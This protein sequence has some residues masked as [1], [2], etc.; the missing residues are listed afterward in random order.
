MKNK[1]I[2]L[3]TIDELVKL[4]S[5]NCTAAEVNQVYFQIITFIENLYGKNDIRISTIS[6]YKSTIYDP[7][8]FNISFRS[9]MQ[10]VMLGQLNTLKHDIENDLIF[11]LEKQ[12]IGS[13]VADFLSLAKV[14]IEEKNKDVAAVLASAAIEDALKRYALLNGLEISEKK[15]D[16]VVNAI[17]SVG[18]LK[19][20]QASLLS[21]Y[22]KTRN[23]AF[24]AEWDNLET[25]EV[26]SLISFTEEFIL[27]NLS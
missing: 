17:K 22:V 9:D 25:P 8:A 11:N 21:A 6:E 4:L 18:L 1:E 26:K 3:K 27:K 23:K 13:V 20:P 5:N 16:E 15:M 2:Y 10:G 12:T 14:S 24:H 19:G 7:K